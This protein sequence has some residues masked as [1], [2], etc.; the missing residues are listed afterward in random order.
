MTKSATATWKKRPQIGVQLRKS[1]LTPEGMEKA[2]NRPHELLLAAPPMPS[3]AEQVDALTRLSAIRR[4]S[5]LEN[6][7]DDYYG[8]DI[9]DDIHSEGTTPYE[10]EGAKDFWDDESL[11]SQHKTPDAG[12]SGRE[13][14][15]TTSGKTGGAAPNEVEPV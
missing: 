3:L 5:A 9:E 8:E 2:D 15:T 11:K 6:L 4:T 1:N 7:P 14:P 13:E 10:V 12:I